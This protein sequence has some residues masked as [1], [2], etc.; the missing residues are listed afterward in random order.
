MRVH[1]GLGSEESAKIEI[2][3]PSGRRD[4]FE[5]VAA[6]RFYLAVEGQAV[7]ADPTVQPV[8]KP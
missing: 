6:R 4:V 1:A 5:S 3:W 7:R 8:R 2:L